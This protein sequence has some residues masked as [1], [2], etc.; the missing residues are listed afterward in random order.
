MTAD[1]Q[2]GWN[3][4]HPEYGPCT[5]TFIGQ[6][7]VGVEFGGGKD[8]LLR[9]ESFR[10]EVQDDN[11]STR[12]TDKSGRESLSWPE[13]TFVSDPAD[14]EHFLGAHWEPFFEDAREMA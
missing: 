5:V 2:V 9:K 12:S 10:G 11:A 4:L 8:A 3:L 13:S 1:F 14:A 6:A 7:H